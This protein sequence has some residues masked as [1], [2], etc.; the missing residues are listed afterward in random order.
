MVKSYEVAG[1]VFKVSASGELLS[2]MRNLIPFEVDGEREEIFSVTQTGFPPL[3]TGDP[4]F[5]SDD[6]PGFPEIAIWELSDGHRFTMTPLPGMSVAAV[7][8]TDKSFSRASIYL[9]GVDDIFGMN[10]CLMLLYAFATACRGALEMHSSVVMN[11]GRG[12]LFLGRSGTGKST[13]SRMWLENIPG[14]ELLNDDNPILR[15]MP[16]GQAR[17]FGSPWSGKTPC[18]KAKDV[19][20]GAVVRIDRAPANSIDRLPPLQAYASL[21]ASASAFRPFK[22]LSGGWHSTLETLA[23]KVPC[24]TLHCLPDGDA[25]R[26]CYNEVHG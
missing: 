4:Y 22:E 11:D 25:A 15:V 13:H 21:M 24:Y 5:C 20:V 7:M 6:G 19:P 17:V 8:D 10:N 16:G 26:V 23:G 18:Y 12:Y 9:T 1:F 3:V 14:T 2:R